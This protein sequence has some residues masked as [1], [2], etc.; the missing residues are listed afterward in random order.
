[1]SNTLDSNRPEHDATS[2][3]ASDDE[4]PPTES[5]MHVEIIVDPS[6][7]AFASPG[8]I[9]RAVRLSAAFR[10][11]LRGEIGVRVTDDGTIRDLNRRHLGHDYA[12][13]VISFGYEAEGDYLSGEMVV[14]ADTAAKMTT[15][16]WSA[17]AELL[18]YVVHGTLHISGMDDHEQYDRVEMRR[19]EQKIMLDLGF[20]NIGRH[21][22][23][24]TMPV[25]DRSSHG[26][27][28]NC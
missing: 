19:A 15:P 13:D 16:D 23:D 22:A 18:L 17:I 2:D 12:T 11:Y 20:L 5:S 1:M 14:S 10:G 24:Q 25:G 3:H 9:E 7:D 28:P 4:P 26:K 6:V 8:M 21:G 27:E